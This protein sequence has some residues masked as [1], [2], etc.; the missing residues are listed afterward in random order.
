MKLDKLTVVLAALAIVSL[1][2]ARRVSAQAAVSHA[3]AAP[4]VA[5]RAS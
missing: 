4:T 3:A 1:C 5:A 2:I